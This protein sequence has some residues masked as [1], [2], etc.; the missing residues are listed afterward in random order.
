[1]VE[2]LSLFSNNI[3]FVCESVVENNTAFGS[4][5]ETMAKKSYTRNKIKE[6]KLPIVLLFNMFQSF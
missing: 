3:K 1:M 4:K 2:L 6:T 5:L